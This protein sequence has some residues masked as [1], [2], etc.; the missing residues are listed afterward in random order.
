MTVGA[1]GSTY[2]GNPLAM[3]VATGRLRRDRPSPRPWRTCDEMAG[4]FGQ[5]L[6]GLKDRFPDVIVD[7][8][9]KGL[10]IGAQADPQQ[11]RVHGRWRA[12]RSC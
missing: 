7:I 9:G 10:L 3:A 6:H 5:Q 4:Y 8:R 2:G 12:T 11:P 1:H